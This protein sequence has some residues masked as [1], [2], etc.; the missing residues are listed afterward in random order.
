MFKDRETEGQPGA[1]KNRETEVIIRTPRTWHVQ[2]QRDNLACSRSEGQPGVFG[3]RGTTWRVL[4]QRNNLACSGTEGQPGVFKIRGTTWRVLEQRNNLACSGTEG[5]SGVFK[6]RGTT[7][8][9]REQRDNLACSRSEG[10]PGVFGSRGTT[11]RVQE[12]RDNLAR[13]RTEGQRQQLRLTALGVFQGFS[14]G[15]DH[16]GVGGAS[17]HHEGEGG[18]RNVGVVE[19]DVHVVH[20]VLFGDV[21][22]SVHAR[23]HLLDEAVLVAS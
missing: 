7:W 14:R 20:A 5:Q 19:L 11:W 3:N 2:Q 15:A 21:A 13:S 12:Q 17:P 6:I 9:V 10:Q 4:E 1:F 8:R 18:V 22:H 23:V 16:G